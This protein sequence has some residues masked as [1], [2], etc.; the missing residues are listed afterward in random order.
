MK[1]LND[2]CKNIRSQDGEDG[3]LEYVFKTIGATNKICVEFGAW[4]GEHLSNTWNLINNHGWR[5]VLIEASQAK[6][7]ELCKKFQQ[8][9]NVRPVNRMVKDSGA[10]SIDTILSQTISSR[11]I[12]LISIDVDGNEYEIWKNMTVICPRVVIVEYNPTIPSH[13]DLRATNQDNFFGS[14]I[15]TLYNL[16]KEKGYEL[17]CATLCNGIFVQKEFYP[18]FNLES[19]D[20]D[21]LTPQKA[22]TWIISSYDGQLFLSAT[23]P[24]SHG[25]D[26]NEFYHWV[27]QEEE[28]QFPLL[29]NSQRAKSVNQIT[30]DLQPIKI[31]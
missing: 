21:Y 18:L 4:D 13:I 5:G 29:V 6:Y 30:L 12:D 26:I 3:V 1:L 20:P 28:K 10:D 24:Y 11:Q 23:P 14:S 16:G 15:R 25:R 27:T 19:N 7:M 8:N 31:R 2:Y 17:V 9:P 22:L